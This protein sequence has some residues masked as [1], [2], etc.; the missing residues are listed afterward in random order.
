ML[1]PPAPVSLWLVQTPRDVIALLPEPAQ[2]EPNVGGVLLNAFDRHRDRLRFHT[3]PWVFTLVAQSPTGDRANRS[4]QMIYRIG[5]DSYAIARTTCRALNMTGE[6]S[7]LQYAVDQLHSKLPPELHYH[8]LCQKHKLTKVR[9]TPLPRP[10]LLESRPSL[11]AGWT[12]LLCRWI[13][14]ST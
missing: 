12:S 13:L 6:P 2:K 8:N 5:D 10:P 11:S 3:R 1:M 9:H 14:G 4:M 7:C